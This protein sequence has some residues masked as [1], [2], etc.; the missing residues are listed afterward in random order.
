MGGQIAP[1]MRATALAPPTDAPSLAHCW[2][3]VFNIY[4]SLTAFD[5]E[6]H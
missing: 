2:S 6:A 3:P 1:W 5:A 4:H